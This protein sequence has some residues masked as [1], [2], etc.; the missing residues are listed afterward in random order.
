MGVDVS[1]SA[2]VQGRGCKY[3]QQSRCIMHIRIVVVVVL[4]HPIGEV[5]V[6]Y[7]VKTSV[8]SAIGLG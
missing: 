3:L 1:L 6:G 4:V 8:C 5:V 7:V 2:V